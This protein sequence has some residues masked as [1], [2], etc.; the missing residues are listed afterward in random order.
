MVSDMPGC[1]QLTSWTAEEVIRHKLDARVS[2]LNFSCNAFVA[3]YNE[4]ANLP[5]YHHQ[6][7][8]AIIVGGYDEFLFL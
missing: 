8:F 5:T 7:I 6:L 2:Y 4:Y 1:A 3:R